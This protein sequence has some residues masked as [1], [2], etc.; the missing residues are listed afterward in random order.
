MYPR[1][2]RG[3]SEGRRGVQPRLFCILCQG[4]WGMGVLCVNEWVEW[5][6]RVALS[7][8]ATEARPSGTSRCRISCL[9]G[10]LVCGFWF[11]MP[12]HT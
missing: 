4:V 10:S 8:A 6:W 12:P 9:F 3:F 5:M 2:L 11:V 1:T 7:L